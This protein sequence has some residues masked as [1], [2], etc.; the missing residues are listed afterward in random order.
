MILP[1]RALVRAPFAWLLIAYRLASINAYTLGSCNSGLHC[2]D[3]S[4][5]ISN[6][7]NATTV[8]ISGFCGSFKTAVGDGYMCINRDCY[9]NTGL[10]CD[11]EYYAIQINGNVSQTAASVIIPGFCGSFK[12]EISYGY[13]CI[14]RNCTDCTLFQAKGACVEAGLGKTFRS[15]CRK[16]A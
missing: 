8:N 6:D 5:A 2:D 1:Y 16:K 3:E 12:S 9:C 10:H 15:W 11:D 14:F 7:N 4:H 13:M